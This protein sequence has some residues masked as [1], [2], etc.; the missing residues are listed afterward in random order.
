M[1][2]SVSTLPSP[3]GAQLHVHERY[4]K[5]PR[6][7]L[8]INHGMAEH[9][10]R[11]ERFA[12]FLHDRGYGTVAHDHRGHG[13]TSARDAPLGSFGKG[14]LPIVLEDID[15]INKHIAERFAGVPIVCFGHSM[16]A[17]LAMNYCLHHPQSIAAG[18]IWNAN[19]NRSAPL[20]LLTLA[21]KAER[22]FKGSDVPSAIARKATFE[23]FNKEFSPTKTDFDWLSRDREEV[24]KYVDDPLCGFDVSVG[25]WLDVLEAIRY[26]GSDS[27]LSALPSSMPFSL[28]AGGADPSTRK[29]KDIELLAERLRG[30]GLRDVAVN[31]F[32]GTR[33]EGLNEINRDEIMHEFADWL[34]A[35]F[36]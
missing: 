33:H 28:V 12:G 20:S 11:Y 34:N 16:G 32:P 3:S 8:Q 10:A 13:H 2:W 24:G 27:N 22:M 30:A 26:A 25:L 1:V 15:C 18:A 5:S 7:I 17:M 9:S 4:P 21:L 6:A 19:L 35:R 31:I 36:S 29:G 23:A 14:G